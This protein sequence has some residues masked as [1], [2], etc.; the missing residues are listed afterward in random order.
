MDL[1]TIFGPTQQLIPDRNPNAITGSQFIQQNLNLT[2]P[3]RDANVLTEVLAG[4]FPSFM[5][6]FKPITVSDGTNT[7]SYLVSSDVICIGSD[8]DFIRIPI[9]AQTGKKILNAFGCSFPTKKI[10]DQIW[11]SATIKLQPMPKGSPYTNDSMQSTQEYSNHNSI[12]QNQLNGL[13]HTQLITGH[14]KDYVLGKAL[15]TSTNNI[16]HL[17]LV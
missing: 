4:N 11:Q 8:M 17:W 12:I 1:T 2:G 5:R 9:M 10:A 3:A 14:K 13:D 16:S 7:L 15:L 6:N